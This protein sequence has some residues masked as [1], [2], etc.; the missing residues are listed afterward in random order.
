MQLLPVSAAL[1]GFHKQILR[2]NERK[3][4]PDTPV[5]DLFIDLKPGADIL[6]EPQN[7][8][9]AEKGFRNRQAPVG[10]I[11][12]RPLQPLCG[13]CQGRIDGKRHEIAAQ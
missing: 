2:G 5:N 8:V 13:S 11:V 9:G 1:D 3:I 4:F 10:G 7:G 6:G 12:E